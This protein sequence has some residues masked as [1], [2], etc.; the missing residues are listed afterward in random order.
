MF[1]GKLGIEETGGTL[2]IGSLCFLGAFMVVDGLTNLYLLVDQYSG[3]AAWA[4]LFSF[5]A[6]VI[7]YILGLVALAVSKRILRVVRRQSAQAEVEE[8]A[9]V[10]M[11]ENEALVS[12][13]LGL[14]QRQ[15]L[16]D[17]GLVGFASMAIGSVFALH[18]LAGYELFGWVAVAGFSILAL[19]CPY[20]GNEYSDYARRLAGIATYHPEELTDK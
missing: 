12:Q 1:S 14:L 6:I 19:A 2:A 11:T 4:V 17:G 9:I 20:L 7:S 10:A 13:Y 3:D 8:F 16:L 18:W 5:P 15:A